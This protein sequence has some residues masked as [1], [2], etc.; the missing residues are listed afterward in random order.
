[1]ILPAN[2]EQV[3]LFRVPIWKASAPADRGACSS[4]CPQWTSGAVVVLI[5]V[6]R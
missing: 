2:I 1:M 4:G 6:R 5:C 3:D